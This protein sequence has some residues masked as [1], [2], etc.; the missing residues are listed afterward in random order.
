MSIETGRLPLDRGTPAA[1]NSTR[2]AAMRAGFGRRDGDQLVLTQEPHAAMFEVVERLSTLEC[3]LQAEDGV[4]LCDLGG[5]TIDL[6]SYRII[7]VRAP[8]KWQRIADFHGGTCAGATIN[9]EF[10]GLLVERFGDAFR[11]VPLREKAPSSRFMRTFEENKQNFGPGSAELMPM[12]LVMNRQ[13]TQGY[14]AN[15]IT[16]TNDDLRNCFDPVVS[17]ITRLIEAYL[18][19][20][21]AQCPSVRINRMVFVGGLSESLH[22]QERLSSHFGTHFTMILLTEPQA[23]VRGAVKCGIRGGDTQ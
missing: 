11:A 14:R 2:N 18:E 15:L 6:A 7:Q 5:G 8:T 16:I 23:V 12:R 19:L 4:L 9:A 13:P 17:K 3:G 21:G 10:Y 22:V 20:T 1:V